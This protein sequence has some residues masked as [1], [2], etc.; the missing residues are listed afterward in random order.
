VWVELLKDFMGKKVGERIHLC[1]E[2]AATL[3]NG[4]LAKSVSDDP[5]QSAI[6]RGIEGALAGFTRGLDGITPLK[7][8][9]DAQSQS[10]PV[11][12]PLIFGPAE[13]GDPDHDFGD[14]LLCVATGNRKRI[15]DHYRSEFVVSRTRAALGESSGS[16]DAVGFG[17]SIPGG[18]TILGIE[19]KIER[20]RRC[21]Y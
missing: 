12:A 20:S 8:F 9:A 17:F 4:G 6:A 5:I 13:K 7:Q 18:S 14:R 19:V 11:G 2:E 10:R 3:V 1:A 15:E 21:S 16:L